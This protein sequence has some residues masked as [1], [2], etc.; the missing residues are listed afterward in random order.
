MSILMVL[1][2]TLVQFAMIG[3]AVSIINLLIAGGPLQATANAMKGVYTMLE[4]KQNLLLLGA[5]RPLYQMT[6]NLLG[7]TMKSDTHRHQAPHILTGNIIP[8]VDLEIQTAQQTGNFRAEFCIYL[9]Q[10]TLAFYMHKWEECREALKR[11]EVLASSHTLLIA[12]LDVQWCF[13]NGMS[14]ICLLQNESWDTRTMAN[15]EAKTKK[16]YLEISERCLDR[17]NEH[18]A[19][20]P[21]LV[22]QKIL[23]LQAEVQVLFGE[24]DEAVGL[25]Q[26]SMKHS[27]KFGVISDHALACERTGL[28]LRAAHKDDMANDY[29]EDSV[30]LYRDYQAA[31]KVNHVKGNVIPGWDD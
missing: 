4:R 17:L 5:I 8:D 7:V 23:M 29:L 15:D 2:F 11:C 13:F 12:A 14:A 26:K 10:A 6:L 18:A 31:A 22:L 20:S 19:A 28:A 27:T 3:T 9:A 16:K 1:P 24:F 21:D 30:Q 25:F